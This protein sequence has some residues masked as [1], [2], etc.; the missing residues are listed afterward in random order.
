VFA[1]VYIFLIAKPISIRRLFLLFVLGLMSATSLLGIFHVQ[2]STS[3]ALDIAASVAVLA[4]TLPLVRILQDTIRLRML[5]LDALVP[6]SGV[7]QWTYGFAL[8]SVPLLAIGYLLD[9]LL[10]YR[11]LTMVPRLM[12]IAGLVALVLQ[13]R[14]NPSGVQDMRRSPPRAQSAAK[15]QPR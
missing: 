13:L 4:W 12:V 9:L 3:Y 14:L 1:F 8:L 7:V 2:H 11:A 6:V 10:H 15:S 5:S